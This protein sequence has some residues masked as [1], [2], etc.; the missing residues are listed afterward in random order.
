MN[1][2][3]V[4]DFFRKIFDELH[5]NI[6]W[7]LGGSLDDQTL[8]WAK[9]GLSILATGTKIIILLLLIGFVYWVLVYLTKAIKKTFG[10]SHRYTRLLRATLRY[11]WF[12][13]SLLAIMSQIGVSP[14][15]IQATAKATTWAGF[16]YI[17]WVFSGQMV[18]GV[19][20]HYDLNAS[21]EQLLKNLL[22]VLILV[23]ALATVLAKFGFDIVSIVAGL[24]IAGLAV[25]WA[26]QSTLANFIAG[27][28]ILIEQSFQVGDWI[29]LDD[30]EGRVVKIS[31]RATQI[32]DRD[33]IIIII[34][35]SAVASSQ[36]VNLTSK[37]MIR[38][39]IRTRIGL[40]ADMTAARSVIIKT[41][42]KDE[43]VLK[44]P[45]PIATVADIGDFGVQIIVRFWVAPLSV[46]RI[47]VIK[48]NLT[49]KIKRSLEEA[50]IPVPY[51]HMKLLFD[52]TAV[53][54][55]SITRLVAQNQSNHIKEK[56]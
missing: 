36:V 45:A 21:I 40:D 10:L 11:L 48:E 29:R 32:L 23:M 18:S 7:L 1:A 14:N 31:L 28:V 34:P 52:E 50:G 39:D 33:N 24:G 15:T 2:H 26:S 44:H 8:N 43:V 51:P 30:K 41:L 19:L 42:Q 13:S 16:Y 27:I 54:D 17:L 47:P 53:Q 5:Q 46:A 25:G 9:L 56:V 6:Y 37:K 12:V 22:L 55:E 49:E 20:K 38:F 35:N 4:I 3:S